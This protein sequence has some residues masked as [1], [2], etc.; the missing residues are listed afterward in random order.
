[1]GFSTA[2][3]DPLRVGFLFDLLEVPQNERLDVLDRVI[4]YFNLVSKKN[5]GT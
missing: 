2:I 4:Y 1:M 5:K 3:I